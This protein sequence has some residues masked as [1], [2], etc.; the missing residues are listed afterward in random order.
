MC[1]RLLFFLTASLDQHSIVP[2]SSDIGRVLDTACV[3]AN[4]FHDIPSLLAVSVFNEN[5]K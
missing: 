4:E 5:K 3:V 1:R 2:V